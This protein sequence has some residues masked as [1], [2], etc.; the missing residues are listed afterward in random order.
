MPKTPEYCRLSRVIRDIPSTDIH[1][2]NQETNFREVA[3]R[4]LA[5]EGVKLREIRSR[6]VKL[7]NI[8]AGDMEL[9]L[10]PYTTSVSEEIFFAF[11][12][13]DY[14]LGFCRLSLPFNTTEALCDELAESAMIREVHVYGQSLV[15]GETSGGRAQHRGLG[16][17]LIQEACLYAKNKDFKKIAVISAIGTKSYYR[18]LGFSD[19]KLYQHKTL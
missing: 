1:E 12:L 6:E 15:F 19:E 11:E 7:Q 8:P 14:L 5:L 13:N 16:K 9:K 4:Q 17:K 18:K 10:Y 3:E 2:G